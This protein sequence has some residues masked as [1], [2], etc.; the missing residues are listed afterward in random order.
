VAEL[1]PA[2]TAGAW[3][4]HDR[5]DRALAGLDDVGAL[6][7]WLA[8]ARLGAATGRADQHDA[9]EERAELQAARS[10]DWAE[11]LRGY[12]AAV[13]GRFRAG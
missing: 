1:G 9:A 3:V 4:P 5:I 11:M 7:A 13:I 2:A 12:T 8:S 10:G 6:E